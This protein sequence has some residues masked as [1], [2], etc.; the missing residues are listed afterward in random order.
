[1]KKINN[2]GFGV[3]GIFLIVVILGLVGGVG[4]L[5]YDKQNSKKEVTVNQ[6]INNVNTDAT[7]NYNN[8]ECLEFSDIKLLSDNLIP[9]KGNIYLNNPFYFKDNST[10][11]DAFPINYFENFKTLNKNAENKSWTIEL[12]TEIPKNIRNFE[13]RKKLYLERARKISSDFQSKS[14][15]SEDRIIIKELED[16]EISKPDDYAEYTDISVMTTLISEC[17]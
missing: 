13:E 14:L 10:D 5:V 6:Q 2:N 16:Y 12:S 8:K 4:W 15:I 11:Y 7:E 3:L 17:K 9:Q 1:M